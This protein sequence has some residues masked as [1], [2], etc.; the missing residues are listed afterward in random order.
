MWGL[1]PPLERGLLGGLADSI[2]PPHSWGE[3]RPS[4]HPER[5]GTAATAD[6]SVPTYGTDVAAG[7]EQSSDPG[8]LPAPVA[9]LVPATAPLA[10]QLV[11]VRHDSGWKPG[12]RVTKVDADWITL[13]SPGTGRTLQKKANG[14]KGPR[15]TWRL[16]VE[17]AAA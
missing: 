12:Y 4:S 14:N 7:S 3:A 9:A 16:Q 6:L 8:S 1:L 15:S 17:V 10:G 13:Q 5:L 11:E 2:D